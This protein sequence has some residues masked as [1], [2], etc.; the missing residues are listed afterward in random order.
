MNKTGLTILVT[1]NLL[2]IDI[3]MIVTY[4]HLTLS[5][6]LVEGNRNN[7]ACFGYTFMHQSCLLHFLHSADIEMLFVHLFN[8]LMSVNLDFTSHVPST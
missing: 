6:Y 4:I 5:Y 7:I 3:I 1:T 8:V 2:L